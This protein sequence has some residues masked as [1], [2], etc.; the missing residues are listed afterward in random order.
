MF[1]IFHSFIQLSLKFAVFWNIKYVCVSAL[2]GPVCIKCPSPWQQFPCVFFRYSKQ[3]WNDP[4]FNTMHIHLM[5]MAHR[6][7]L[8][9]SGW[10][11]RWR[12]KMEGWRNAGTA[13]ANKHTRVCTHTRPPARSETWIIQRSGVAEDR[14]VWS[15]N[16]TH[17]YSFNQCFFY[18]FIFSW[19]D[20][21]IFLVLSCASA[22]L[23]HHNKHWYWYIG[24]FLQTTAVFKRYHLCEDRC[25]KV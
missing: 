21:Y 11:W 9:Q 22:Q 14:G 1:P 10:R 16:L 17:N 7:R 3:C 12:E 19:C 24:T 5:R 23:S 8:G 20:A 6:Q 13:Q 25:I 4:N 15:A 2:D 18:S